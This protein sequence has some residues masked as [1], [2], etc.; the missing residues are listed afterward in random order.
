MSS[1]D[2]NVP[3]TAPETAAAPAKP[4]R[5]RKPAAKKAK[6]PEKK[7]E[8]K[9]HTR[10]IT[11]TKP[12]AKHK[13]KV[14]PKKTAKKPAAKKSAAKVKA[15]KKV[16]IGNNKRGQGTKYIDGALYTMMQKALPP[17][18]INED[19]SINMK[20]LAP[21]V[22]TSMEGV[23]KWFRTNKVA[24]EKAMRLINVTKG[25]LQIKHFIPFVFGK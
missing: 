12:A 4:K 25:K 3:Q 7:K 19:K 18:F 23:Y 15:A 17:S 8:V 24:P 10:V 14:A 11:R 1:P 2:E 16:K 13:A 22:K 9:A 21:A 6:A 20:K 5:V